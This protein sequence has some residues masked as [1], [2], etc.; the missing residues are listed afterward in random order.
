MDRLA[1]IEK[2][3]DSGQSQRRD[4]PEYDFDSASPEG[5]VGAIVFYA[6]AIVLKPS[7]LSSIESA[8]PSWRA[9]LRI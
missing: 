6:Y 1:Q 3:E 2:L 5:R 8:L 4:L 9:S 7:H